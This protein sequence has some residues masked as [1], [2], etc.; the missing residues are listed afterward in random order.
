[1]FYAG[2]ACGLLLILITPFIKKLM[3]GIK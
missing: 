1:L 3:H 2:I